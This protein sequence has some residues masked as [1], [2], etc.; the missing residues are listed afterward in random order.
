MRIEDR[1]ITTLSSKDIVMTFLPDVV[2]STRIE[3]AELADHPRPGRAV[4]GRTREPGSV[5]RECERGHLSR[6][7]CQ[8]GETGAG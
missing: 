8:G 3:S 4:G 6:M 7:T 5:R 2:T 1:S